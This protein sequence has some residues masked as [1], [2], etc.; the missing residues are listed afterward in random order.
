MSARF[1]QNNN[2][3]DKCMYVCVHPTYAIQYN[4]LSIQ[5][6]KIGSYISPDILRLN[7][8]ICAVK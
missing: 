6:F 1:K 5:Y 2:Q 8:P 4:H 7:S 3:M